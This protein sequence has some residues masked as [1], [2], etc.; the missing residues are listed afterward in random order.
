MRLLVVVP[1]VVVA[2]V[3]VC[4]A[5]AVLA[6]C[7]TPKSYVEI[8]ACAD[9]VELEGQATRLSSKRFELDHTFDLP[10][11]RTVVAFQ[12]LDQAEHRYDVVSSQPDTVRLL[13][14]A[15]SGIVGGLLLASATYDV[16]V[17]GRAFF[18]ERPF[19][20]T[21][22]GGGLATLGVLGMSTGWHPPARAFFFPD[23]V[24]A[25]KPSTAKTSTA[26]ER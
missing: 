11:S 25:A 22:V 2:V 26:I 17:G 4:G 1:V 7:E 21:V 14:G 20:Q 15:A 24:C 6:G 19:Y 23:D 16:A 3:V 5:A 8:P 13:L 18:T 9:R 10:F 12:G